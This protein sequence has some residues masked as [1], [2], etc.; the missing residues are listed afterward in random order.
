MF[1]NCGG[2]DYPC[3]TGFPP[4][5]GRFGRAK[6]GRGIFGPAKMGLGKKNKQTNPKQINCLTSQVRCADMPAARQKIHFFTFLTNKSKK[7]KMRPPILG[8]LGIFWGGAGY[9]GQNRTQREKSV[10]N[11]G[12]KKNTGKK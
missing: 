6:M 5:A 4:P 8:I 7:S 3:F 9:R 1:G 10:S 11:M 2:G 12:V